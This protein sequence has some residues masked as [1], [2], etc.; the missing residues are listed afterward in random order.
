MPEL[1][2]NVLRG[3]PSC[4]NG[5]VQGYDVGVGVGADA[6]ACGWDL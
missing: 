1:L 2:R 6:S 4:L 3:L 5:L